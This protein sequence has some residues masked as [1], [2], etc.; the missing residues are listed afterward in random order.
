MKTDPQANQEMMGQGY[1]EHMVMP[2][3]PTARFVLV[4]TNFA[5]VLLK[6]NLDRPSHPA[7]AH[8]LV[9]GRLEGGIAKVELDHA[10]IV[11]IAADDQPDCGA[12]QIGARF[13]QS[14]ERKVAYNG[15]FAAL[16]D[17]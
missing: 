8:E 15:T 14:Q 2:A 9:Q 13:N 6:N 4:Q 16:F 3:Q 7:N 1:Q 5:F 10:W 11:Q 12:R 17:A